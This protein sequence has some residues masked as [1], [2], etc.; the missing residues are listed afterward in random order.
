MSSDAEK[1]HQKKKKS[2]VKWHIAC[3]QMKVSI[4]NMKR[5]CFCISS[6]VSFINQPVVLGKMYGVRSK[7]IVSD[8]MG[9]CQGVSYIHIHGRPSR[10]RCSVPV[11]RL[12][13]LYV[14]RDY[15]SS[16][17]DVPWL[18]SGPRRCRIHIHH[19]PF[20]FFL[21]AGAPAAPA[22]QLHRPSR[23]TASAGKPRRIQA[24]FTNPARRLLSGGA[25]VCQQV[26]RCCCFVGEK[27][28]KLVS[29]RQRRQV[30]PRILD[31]DSCMGHGSQ[32]L[33]DQT[34]LLLG[35]NRN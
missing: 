11:D 28:A 9:R 16:S 30:P 27:T 26:A 19:A 14:L 22:P 29:V 33:A 24:F 8:A 18:A 23:V 6:G 7:K 32:I 25:H 15:I 1:P 13:N 3:M 5:N 10:F 2:H 31:W 12:C 20:P 4:F 17:R 35:H 34:Q 21:P